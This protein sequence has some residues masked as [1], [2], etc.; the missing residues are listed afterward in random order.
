MHN[1][2]ATIQQQTKENV[3]VQLIRDL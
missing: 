3:W 2:I 1:S